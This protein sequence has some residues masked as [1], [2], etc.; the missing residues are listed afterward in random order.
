M[1][2]MHTLQCKKNQMTLK[3]V[4]SGTESSELCPLSWSWQQ[5]VSWK[6]NFLFLRL[7]CLWNLFSHTGSK[8]L[9]KST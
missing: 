4:M 7:C 9:Y 3:F 5:I 8:V 1:V 2:E 6:W